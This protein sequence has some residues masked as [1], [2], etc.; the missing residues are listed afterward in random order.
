MLDPA[1]IR[2]TTRKIT[3]DRAQRAVLMVVWEPL[4]A[5]TT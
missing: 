2:M 4:V 5:L 3:V 1:T